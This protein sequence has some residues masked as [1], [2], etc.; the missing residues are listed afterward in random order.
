MSDGHPF[1]AILD[2]YNTT[3]GL[4]QVNEVDISSRPG[5]GQNDSRVNRKNGLKVDQNSNVVCR[6]RTNGMTVD[7][8]ESRVIDWKGQP[9]TAQSERLLEHANRTFVIYQRIQSI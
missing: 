7:V 9:P 8:N 5:P 6:V 1:H 4:E 2:Y 3:H